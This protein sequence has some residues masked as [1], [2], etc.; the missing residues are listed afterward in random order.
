[1][2]RAFFWLKRCKTISF[3]TCHNKVVNVPTN[4]KRGNTVKL[5]IKKSGFNI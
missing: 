2:K 3:I 4:T 1:M 5:I